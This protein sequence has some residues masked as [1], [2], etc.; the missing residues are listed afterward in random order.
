MDN[1]TSLKPIKEQQHSFGRFSLPIGFSSLLAMPFLI[2]FLFLL[3]TTK[4]SA[5][6]VVGGEMTYRCLGNN[7]YEITLRVYRDCFFGDLDA[8]FD[9]TASVGI[10]DANNL[11]VD[12]LNI[13]Y[14][15]IND[16]LEVELPDSC[17][18]IPSTICVHTTIYKDTVTLLPSSGGYTIAYQRC[19]RNA[20]VQNIFDPLET[21]ATFSVRISELALQECNTGAQFGDWPPIF[22]CVN[23]PIVWDHSAFDPDGDSLVYSLCT[24]LSGGTLLMGMPQPPAA[25]P[26]NTVVW[27]DPPYN[28]DNLMGGPDP[29]KIDA[30]TGELTGTPNVIGQFVVGVC[31]E[32]YRDGE[33]ISIL[34]RDFQYNVGICG[35]VTAAIDAPDAQCDE[36]EVEF[37]NNSQFSNDFLWEFNDPGNPGATS[38]A[39]SPTYTFSDTGTYIINLIAEPGSPCADTTQHELFLQTNSL[40]AD[41][42]AE[43]LECGD[44]ISVTGIDLSNDPVS[45]VN[46][47]F[48]EL[49]YGATTLTST[50]EQPTFQFPRVDGEV[51]LSLT[52]R[53]ANGCEQTASLS[54]FV[55]PVGPFDL[56]QDSFCICLGES[57][58]INPNFVADFQYTWTPSDG[59]SATNTPNPTANPDEST[60][61][62]VLVED[63]DNNCSIERTVFVQVKQLQLDFDQQLSCDGLTVAFIN[64]TIDGEAYRWDFGDTTTNADTSTLINPVYTYPDTGLYTVRLISQRN[65]PCINE[66]TLERTL[67]LTRPVA[68]ANAEV[69]YFNCTEGEILV[70]VSENA[71]L[72]QGNVVEW[73]WAFSTGQTFS[74]QFPPFINFSNDGDLGVQL[75]ITT[76]EGCQDSIEQTFPIDIIDG[77]QMEDTIIICRGS[78]AFLNPGGDSTYSYL[79]SPDNFID[80]PTSF[81]PEVSPNQ[82]TTYTATITAISADTCSISKDVFA[83][84][85]PDFGLTLPGSIISCSNEINIGVFSP[86]GQEFVWQNEVGDT[87][88]TGT[89]I[90]VMPIG[91]ETYFVTVSDVF[92]CTQTDSIDVT[93]NGINIEVQDTSAFCLGEPGN[94]AVT[95]LDPNDDLTFNWSP[96]DNILAGASSGSPLVET[97]EPGMT[98]YTFQ[99]SNQFGCNTTGAV[100]AFVIDTSDQTSFIDYAQCDGSGVTVNFV[101][102]GPNAPFYTWYFGDSQNP[103]AT[104]TGPSVS[105]TYPSLGMYTVTLILELP[106]CP[107]TITL[108]VEVMEGPFLNPGFSWEFTEC[109]ENFVEIS[110]FDQ[111]SHP[112]SAILAWDWV[113]SNGQTSQE[114]NPVVTLTEDQMLEAT[115]VV[116][117]LGD[118]IDS[119]TQVLEVD[120]I[121]NTFL[122]DSLLGCPREALSLNDNGDPDLTY[123]WPTLEDSTA[124]NPVV[125]PEISIVYPVEVSTISDGVC[126]VRDSVPVTIFPLLNYEFHEDTTVCDEVLTLE[127]IG[128]NVSYFVWYDGQ[129]EII[130]TAS[131][132]IVEPN[133]TNTYVLAAFDANG[134]SEEQEIMIQGNAVNVNL[135]NAVEAVCENEFLQVN[136]LNSDPSDTL[137]YDWQPASL[138]Q[139]GGDSALPMINTS[140]SGSFE[141]TVTTTNQFGC[142]TQDTTS[143]VIIDDSLELAFESD[144]LCDGVTA[145]FFNQSTGSPDYIWSFGDPANP[146]FMD[147]GTDP[148]YT[149]PD[150]GLYT[151]QLTIPYNVSCSDTISQELFIG[152]ALLEADFGVEY[153]DCDAA[154]LEVL[155][156][157]Q[158][159]NVQDNT[160]SWEW[161]INGDLVSTDDQAT[162]VITQDTVLE[163]LLIINTT[164]DCADSIFQEVPIDLIGDISIADTLIACPGTG[165]FLNPDGDTTLHYTWSPATGLSDSTAANPFADPGIT[166]EYALTV[167]NFSADTCKVDRN[168]VVIVPEA[169]GLELPQDATTCENELELVAS[170]QVSVSYEWS[171]NGQVIS[172]DSSV[173]VNPMGDVIYSLS[174]S[175]AFG[176]TQ[177]DEVMIT[178]NGVDIMVE[179]TYFFCQDSVATISIFNMDPN[180]LLSFNW[181]P[182]NFIIS[183]ANSPNVEIDISQP[184]T[185]EIYL[186]SENQLECIRQD[187]I[188]IAVADTSDQAPFVHYGQCESLEVNFAHNGP[189]GPYMTWFFGDPTDP[190]ASA[191]GSMVSHTYPATG[192]YVVTLVLSESFVDCPDTLLLPIEVVDGPYLD[193]DFEWNID[194]C[195]ADS[196][197]VDFTDLSS[198]VQDDIA[199]WAWIYSNGV[200]D[201][202]QNPQLVVYNTQELIVELQITTFAGCVDSIADTLQLNLLDFDTPDTLFSCDGAPVELNPGGNPAYTYEWWPNIGLDE[203]DVA[204]PTASP[205]SSI[206]YFVNITDFSSG[207]TCKLFRKVRVELYEG[208]AVT[209]PEDQL[210]CSPGSVILEAST[211]QSI[212]I[213]WSDQPDFTPVISTDPSLE[214]EAGEPVYYYVRVKDENDCVTEDSILVGNFGPLLEMGEDVAICDSQ[215]VTL[216]AQNLVPED[217]LVYF[218]MPEEDILEGAQS[219]NPVVN[220]ASDRTYYLEAT[221]QFGC[222]IIDSVQVVVEDFEN[223]LLVTASPASI[224]FGGSAQ[225][226]ATFNERYQYQWTPSPTLDRD[227]VYN[228]EATP[229]QT[230]TYTLEV[231]TASGCVETRDLVVTVVKRACD[232]PFIFVPEAFTPNGDGENDVLFVRGNP[233]DA[234]EMI[235]YNRWGEKVFETTSKDYGWDGTY[236]GERLSPDVYGYYLKVRC[237]DGDEF[238]KKGNVTLLR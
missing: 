94:L 177:T 219:L 206:T 87:I 116:K 65:A 229:E 115:L 71:D 202:V 46:G 99:A 161:Y 83:A 3:N 121:E 217:T 197:I 233:I 64:T 237:L 40:T 160:E 191:T 6:H 31:V 181:E 159:L 182:A 106:S 138:I 35:E 56:L 5:T 198:H 230:T 22:V 171:E 146:G 174:V 196:L 180:D 69:S 168:V 155:F 221:N 102:Q 169:I 227:D 154:E 151:I 18:Q 178:G 214:V 235:I 165:V 207:D 150:S 11:L 215:P 129:G 85:P 93:S 139:S 81:N 54:F 47:W 9:S 80:D 194:G 26:Y 43:I 84:V 111:S 110:F 122:P 144:I 179:D 224:P 231:T 167:Q 109:E 118:C 17:L 131:S 142:S 15:G 50:L 34:R 66:D 41:L 211:S 200:T 97:T 199:Q 128:Y 29:L 91:T 203:T 148:S 75:T 49:T 218:W 157:D 52:A 100:N 192:D 33:L 32:E 222:T 175:D 156:F 62:T 184:G 147:V 108:P 38:T 77:L 223:D 76:D 228:P 63:A 51:T 28:L 7:E 23:D 105:Y 12:T 208:A 162:A 112:Q 8:F 132:V 48:W 166:T 133:G 152:G 193:V 234:I 188:M 149:Y 226:L 117:S 107:D 183:G 143:F 153:T 55:D 78:S 158:S 216:S 57:I 25:P 4:V 42:T 14:T 92:D 67:D 20:T 140:E 201:S 204:N 127:A 185:F 164:L 170:T 210:R 126:T 90:T 86:L 44:T 13:P 209:L 79:W 176:C 96:A 236:N 73:D 130:D 39:F 70:E 36:L 60:T 134:C 135:L 145:E 103:D 104:A 30:Q 59:L 136:L 119:I 195:A 82:T 187:T 101:N 19:C 24:P 95:N 21:G 114:Q 190:D 225:L 189:N 213:E 10:F 137:T 72:L 212:D 61:Y 232:E 124:Q 68:L 141:L 123:F 113:F 163:V 125:N 53:S 120:V 173:L 2:A 238:I 98:L 27:K 74:G 16:T 37:D 220:P 172:T 89:D 45:P 58:P 205:Q 1:F 186:T 88:G